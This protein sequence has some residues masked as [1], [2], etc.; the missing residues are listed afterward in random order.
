MCGG[1]LE[2]ELVPVYCCT[3]YLSEEVFKLFRSVKYLC[4]HKRKEPASVY[5]KAQCGIPSSLRMR[6]AVNPARIP[7]FEDSK[8][9]SS[10]E[11]TLEASK[12]FITAAASK[13]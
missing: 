1:E 3:T 10:T 7:H 11:R 8:L 4:S 6:S 9:S 13:R 2:L 12:L 5:T